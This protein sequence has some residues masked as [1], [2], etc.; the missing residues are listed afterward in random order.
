MKAIPHDTKRESDL[1]RSIERRQDWPLLLIL[2]GGVM[3]WLAMIWAIF[4]FF[5][6]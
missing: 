4:Q 5:T 3:F 2:L 6:A 1:L